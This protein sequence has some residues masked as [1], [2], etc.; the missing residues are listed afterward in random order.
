MIKVLL[1]DDHQLISDALASL[2]NFEN[3]IQVVGIALNGN[4]VLK[5]L[6]EKAV[7][8]VILDIEM[9][10]L[11]GIETAK[12]VREDFPQV[13][14][15]ILT[16]YKNKK[17]VEIFA[18]IGVEGYI[19]KE[20]SRSD[21]LYALTE[22]ANGDIY[23]GESMTKIYLKSLKKNNKNEQKPLTKREVEVLKLMASELTSKEISS[24]LNIEVST[25]DTHK[26]NMVK[27]L[28]VKGALG[29]VRYATE[30]GFVENKNQA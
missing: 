11:N 6:K 28:G 23:W 1:A 18:E 21:L 19:L 27:K 30:N 24:K 2:L 20:D 14:I 26:K 17:Y 9:P 22:I 4:E 10:G 29:L 8:I 5:I 15:L 16:M 7:D 12:K 3:G 25:V 13:K